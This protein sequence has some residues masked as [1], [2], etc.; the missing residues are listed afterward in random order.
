MGRKYQANFA[1][2]ELVQGENISQI[3]FSLI[4]QLAGGATWL[5][6]MR[7]PFVSFKTVQ[8]FIRLEKL[9]CS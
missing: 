2:D 6:D 3:Q 4:I 1:P 7:F 5:A 8:M 9:C